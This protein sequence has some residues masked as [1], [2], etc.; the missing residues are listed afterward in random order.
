MKCQVY[1][2]NFCKI[3]RRRGKKTHGHIILLE[4][5][6]YP[7]NFAFKSNKTINFNTKI[8]LNPNVS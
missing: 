4:S 7:N 5:I 6:K 2:S 1:S 3:K 8:Y